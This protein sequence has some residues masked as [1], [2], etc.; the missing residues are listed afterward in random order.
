MVLDQA[1]GTPNPP[2]CPICQV[3]VESTICPVC[4]TTIN[5]NQVTH[6]AYWKGLKKELFN[7]GQKIRWTTRTLLFQPGKAVRS[8]TGKQDKKTMHPVRFLFV[9]AGLNIVIARW[10]DIGH[11]AVHGD[12]ETAI[13]MSRWISQY[14]SFIW[15]A[16]IPAMALSP[17]LIERRRQPSYPTHLGVVTYM[18]AINCLLAIPFFLIEWTWPHLGAVRMVAGM[19]IPFIYST[20]LFYHVYQAPLARTILSV[21]L[22]WTFGMLFFLALYVGIYLVLSIIL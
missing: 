6:S 17:W 15:I 1:A 5:Q 2:H 9:L 10:L 8:W 7:H 11:G 12:N 14:F 3:S 18:T 16:L 20:W 19:S 4:G 22:S 13:L 21:L